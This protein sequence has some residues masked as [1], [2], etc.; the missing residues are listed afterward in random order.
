[1]MRRNAHYIVAVL[2]VLVVTALAVFAAI[3]PAAANVVLSENVLVGLYALLSLAI[4]LITFGAIGDSKALV[5]VN[6]TT[7]AA[8][9][10]GGSA[11]GF[12]IFFYLLSSGLATHRPLSVTLKNSVGDLPL[13]NGDGLVEVRL[14]ADFMSQIFNTNTGRALFYVPRNEDNVALSI[15]GVEGRKWTAKAY[16]PESCVTSQGQVNRTCRAVRVSLVQDKVCFE[17]T[18]MGFDWPGGQEGTLET[19]LELVIQRLARPAIDQAFSYK[20]SPGVLEHQLQKQKFKILK[21]STSGKGIC[22][23]LRHLE[24][25][26]NTDVGRYVL[27]TYEDGCD[28]VLVQLTG[29]P[30]PKG[31][32]PCL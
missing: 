28:K 24:T 14:D 31:Y 27:R 1:M 26:F 22:P 19:I 16:E 9:R 6:G 18:N 5:N 23:H 29:E 21:R 17:D 32:T 25:S 11:A 4:A 3:L 10:V 7:G 30:E 12:V 8:V 20:F 15:K 13:S 2:L